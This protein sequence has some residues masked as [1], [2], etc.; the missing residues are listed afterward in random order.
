M[1]IYDN[2]R[3]YDYSNLEV[4][5]M[6][7]ILCRAIVFT[8]AAGFVVLGSGYAPTSAQTRLD[9]EYE[10]VEEYGV[11]EEAL[12]GSSGKN[13]YGQPTAYTGEEKFY[14]KGTASW[15]GREFHGKLT[16]SGEKFDMKEFTAAHKELP[17]GTIIEVKNL[18]N[19]SSIRAK[20]NDRGPYRAN[21]I[22]DLSYAA[23]NELGYIRD[24][25]TMVGITIIKWGDGARKTAARTIPKEST[26]A[27]EPVIN[28]Y[29]E[30]TPSKPDMYVTEKT[31]ENLVLQAGAFYSKQNAESFKNKL[32]ALTGRNV[33]VVSDNEMFKVRIEGL[34]DRDDL[35]RTKNILEDENIQSFSVE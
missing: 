6:T 14:Q 16:A 1:K 12:R 5:I 20:V 26:A 17:F 4:I 21:R 25:E 31:G 27:V 30:A 22:L 19:G 7:N 3:Y 28:Y 2:S 15:Y 13:A 8:A 34:Y 11:E 9:S 23:A 18:K 33:V 35:L 10:A 29:E 24:G 32:K